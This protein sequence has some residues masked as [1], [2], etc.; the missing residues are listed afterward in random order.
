MLL[1]SIWCILKGTFWR[2]RE[3]SALSF[4][5]PQFLECLKAFY[6]KW[7]LFEAQGGCC[8][9]F[10]VQSHKPRVPLA[11]GCRSPGA[12]LWE[13]LVASERACSTVCYG[14]RQHLRGHIPL[15][16]IIIYR[17][18]GFKMLEWHVC[19]VLYN[20]ASLVQA[21]HLIS[22]WLIFC[23]YKSAAFGPFILDEYSA[24]VSVWVSERFISTLSVS[25]I[26]SSF[27]SLGDSSCERIKFLF[28]SMFMLQMFIIYS[29][30]NLRKKIVWVCF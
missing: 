30:L 17:S 27:L 5:P 26:S 13:A 22:W 2:E 12:T 15:E 21:C 28:C 9:P 16:I 24:T 4:L 3:I 19:P 25:Q 11:P 8:F 7:K 6:P 10:A 1:W 18:A 20:P 14:V 23:T 29:K